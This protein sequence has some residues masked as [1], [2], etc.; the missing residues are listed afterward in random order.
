MSPQVF[1]WVREQAGLTVA[2]VAAYVHKAPAD[3]AAWEAGTAWPTYRQLEQLAQGLLHRPVA[4][5]FLPEPPDEPPAQ[6]EFRTL[7]DFDVGK[8]GADARYA[9]REARAYQQSLRELTGE[10]NPSPRRLWEDLHFT[11]R[12][13]VEECAQALREYLG[14]D[15]QQQSSWISTE[16]AIAQWRTAVEAAGVFVFK[17]SFKQREI[18]GFC[19]TD[20]EF[21]I[22]MI[23]NST[24]FSRQVFTLLHEVAH[25]LAGTSSLTTKDGRFVERMQGD[26]RSLEIACN[27]LAAEVLVPA[28]SF[29]WRDIDVTDIEASVGRAAR[30][31]NVSREVILRRVRDR[32]LVD[33][34]TYENYAAVWAEQAERARGGGE[35]TGGNYYN[36]RGAYLGDAFL[37]LAFSSYRAG[38]ID[39]V[40]LSQ[41]LGMKARYVS[42]FEERLAGRV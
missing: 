20:D 25:L 14:I 35:E 10:R 34:A 6:H 4:L 21:P 40:D 18:S 41:H 5:F 27:K 30:R 15:L 37:K 23:N 32:G 22:V 31:F 16:Q 24:P 17:R 39:V 1:A 11:A 8:L 13:N 7:P 36:T 29:P 33:D 2:D 38:L 9:I 3:V 26:D 28:S 19:L 42:E 12:D